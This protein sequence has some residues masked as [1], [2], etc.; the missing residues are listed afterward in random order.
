M[1]A[2]GNIRP[3]NT[4]GGTSSKPAGRPPGDHQPEPGNLPAMLENPRRQLAD[5]PSNLA[6]SA[7]SPSSVTTTSAMNITTTSTRLTVINTTAG[8]AANFTST[9]TTTG[10]MPTTTARAERAAGKND[11][12]VGTVRLTG[13]D[14]EEDGE[15]ALGRHKEQQP[16]PRTLIP[17]DRSI[18]RLMRLS[19]TE[20]IE[21]IFDQPPETVEKHFSD[22]LRAAAQHPDPLALEMLQM[23]QSA[24]RSTGVNTSTSPKPTGQNTMEAVSPAHLSQR[25]IRRDLLP[26]L[27]DSTKAE[28]A[29]FPDAPMCTDICRSPETPADPKAQ[30]PFQIRMR[31]QTM[32]TAMGD[33]SAS[34]F[35]QPEDYR[36]S[37]LITNSDFHGFEPIRTNIE[38]WNIVNSKPNTEHFLPP[39]SSPGSPG[40]PINPSFPI[41][42]ANTTTGVYTT[43]TTIAT[44][45]TTTTSTM[46]AQNQHR[47][48]KTGAS[49]TLGLP[50]G[51]LAE[52]SAA[53]QSKVS[54]QMDLGNDANAFFSDLN[55]VINTILDCDD[56]VLIERESQV[57]KEVASLSTSTA[58]EMLLARPIAAHPLQPGSNRGWHA[59]DCPFQ[60][61]TRHKRPD[62]LRILLNFG[63][64]PDGGLENALESPTV[65]DWVKNIY[66]QHIFPN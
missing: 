44:T 47:A 57:I 59:E 7:A 8:S 35:C 29:N 46:P 43:T 40:T 10:T 2:Q 36:G 49:T 5:T 58:L 14:P 50:Q 42:K 51:T 26:E 45:T 11:G 33:V 34:R 63:A 52:K 9:S 20:L 64:R 21:D 39:N 54:D 4:A 12:P 56:A 16:A 37:F 65:P 13:R 23:R 53:G 15:H 18:S 32:P 17:P 19:E 38:R 25:H 30:Q 48:D 62:N 22:Y 27:D 41:A 61:A 3:I 55:R 1:D 6:F 60:A 66:R 24:F 28:K 31:P